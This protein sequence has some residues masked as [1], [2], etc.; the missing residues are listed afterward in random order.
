MA[1][2]LRVLLVEDSEN[3]ALL[4][5]RK[6]KKAG[7]TLDL[8]RVENAPDMRKELEHDSWDLIISDYVLPTFNGLEAL[9]LLKKTGRDLPF[10]IVSGKIGED[11]AVEAMRAGAHDY[12]MKNNLNRLV[13]AIKRE[14]QDARVRK[15]RIQVREDLQKSYQELEKKSVQV[16]KTNAKLQDEV[17]I[18]K[19]AEQ[20]ALENKEYL[21]NV[22]N[23]ASEIM[24]A[25]DANNRITMW[26]NTAKDIIGYQPKEVGNRTMFKLPL[27]TNPQQIKDLIHEIY[28]SKISTHEDL[29]VITKDNVKRIIRFTGSVIKGKD[30]QDLGILFVGKDIT[31]D[32]EIHGKLLGGNIYLLP[33]KNSKAALDLFL[34]LTRSDHQGYIITR[35]NLD[36]LKKQFETS[37]IE[38]SILSQEQYP[39]YETVSELDD[40]SKRVVTFISSHPNA[41]VLLD[42]IH[43]LLTKNSFENFLNTLYTLHDAVARYNSML[44][45]RID[46]QLLTPNQMAVLENE[47]RLLPSQKVEGIVIEDTVYD[48]LK[49]IYEQNQ[50]NALVPY[51]KIMGKFKI[52]YS[53]A[54][55]RLEE[56][57]NKGLVFTKRQGKLRTVFISEKG[58]MLLHKRVTA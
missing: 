18:R 56:L 7:Y 4:L 39:G 46:P 54:A 29:V 20:E 25:I 58:K 48:M 31:K 9:N 32:I 13:P 30:T 47:L 41:V 33:D 37:K 50:N 45:L 26:N 23:S 36:T 28:Q 34:D 42:G 17:T 57:E 11:T 8:H 52:A 38:A 15:D 21:Q 16:E 51:K 49:Y 44:F 55:K 40:L 14:L 3:D 1:Q 19:K 43:Y 22:I 53:T 10:I 2:K 24:I 12:I 27:F 5:E 6:L 35:L